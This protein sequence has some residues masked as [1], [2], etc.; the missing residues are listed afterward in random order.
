MLRNPQ[1]HLL[2]IGR[3]HPQTQASPDHQSRHRKREQVFQHRF[4]AVRSLGR[5]ILILQMGGLAVDK[6]GF[7]SS[8]VSAAEDFEPFA[9]AVGR[10]A[11]DAVEEGVRAQ[12]RVRKVSD[13]AVEV[14]GLQGVL[15][16]TG[17]DIAGL[18][19][20]DAAA[21][22]VGA[23]GDGAEVGA[24][25]GETAGA[26]K[27]VVEEGA[28]AREAEVGGHEGEF[29]VHGR[30]ADVAAR[31][32][33]VGIYGVAVAGGD[34]AAQV[35]GVGFW[36]APG[37]VFEDGEFLRGVVHFD[38]A[39]EAEVG[40]GFDDLALGGEGAVALVVVEAE[41]EGGGAVEVP[42]G[43]AAAADVGVEGVIV[44]AGAPELI[45]A[46]AEDTAGDEGMGGGGGWEANDAVR[47]LEKIRD[48]TSGY[49]MPNS[50]ETFLK[51]NNMQD[52]E[53]EHTYSL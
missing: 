4:E 14:A 18:L 6:H 5:D 12:G 34:P 27:G 10:V 16:E 33:R 25:D 43:G 22:D 9:Y 29:R 46:F 3:R 32:E 40:K 47:R 52:Y 42:L 28:G 19:A 11:D 39:F 35:E 50:R 38:G 24:G 15:V 31:F 45:D 2:V 17:D 1:L 21:V 41:F 51:A 8:A 7:L 13:E 53:I 20:A 26:D 30:G 37:V 48:G 44:C 36:V 49:E 23:G